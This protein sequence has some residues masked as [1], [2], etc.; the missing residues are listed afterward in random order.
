MGS[1]LWTVQGYRVV[2]LAALLPSRRVFPARIAGYIFSF[3]SDYSF[4][5]SMAS[6]WTTG[7]QSVKHKST[8][9]VGSEALFKVRTG[10]RGIIVVVCSHLAHLSSN[11]LVRVIEMKREI[12]EGAWHV[13]REMHRARRV[14]GDQEARCESWIGAFQDLWTA[15]QGHSSGVCIARLQLRV[16]GLDVFSDHASPL[17]QEVMNA[18]SSKMQVT[19]RARRFQ[20]QR[21]ISSSSRMRRQLGITDKP[22]LATVV[23]C[24][25]VA[26]KKKPS[27]DGSVIAFST[28]G[29][30]ITNR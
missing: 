7:K 19:D 14:C 10:D 17:I 5:C 20:K 13:A 3:V 26:L 12:T 30:T 28:T 1:G 4:S 23:G 24:Q 25:P 21:G 11:E 29:N 22:C 15:K 27:P 18:V 6:L 2:K 16:S 8:V 9:S